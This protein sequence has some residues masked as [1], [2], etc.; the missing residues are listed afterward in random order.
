MIL[1]NKKPLIIWEKWQDPF[2][3]DH[4]I[5]PENFDEDINDEDIEDYLEE[6]PEDPIEQ[7]RAF[8]TT[9]I[10]TPMG[11]LPYTEKTA[12]S[13][14]FKFWVGHTNF[15]ITSPI[16]SIIN[17]SS[18]VEALDIFTRYRFRIAVG[19]AFKDSEVMNY[20]NNRVYEHIHE[21]H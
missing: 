20:I 7:K 17:E 14:I 21:H 15:S 18:G 12:C 2:L 13:S 9:M 19:K 10:L 8:R 16:E 3:P 4:F 5:S 6:N 11:M 1:R